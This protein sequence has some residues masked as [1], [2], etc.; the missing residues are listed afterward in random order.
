M[1]NIFIRLVT[2]NFM[3]FKIEIHYVIRREIFSTV[4]FDSAAIVLEVNELSPTFSISTP[5]LVIEKLAE[6]LNVSTQSI[7]FVA[8]IPS[9]QYGSTALT[10]PGFSSNIFT[11]DI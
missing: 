8:E 9:T 1:K 5:S 6:K 2:Q 11:P 4:T 3:N 7:G 10:A